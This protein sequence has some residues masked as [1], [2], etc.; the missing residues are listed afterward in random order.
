MFGG[1]AAAFAY[2]TT[3]AAASGFSQLK[4]GAGG[5][6]SGIGA[7]NDGTL[8][9][10]TDVGGA[11][12]R[13]PGGSAWQQLITKSSWPVGDFGWQNFRYP[14]ADGG[15]FAIAIAP[16]NSQVI[17]VS[18][19]QF[20]F[21]S[22]N[23][24]A[25]FTR[26]SCPQDTGSDANGGNERGNNNRLAVD[27]ANPAICF[28][29]GTLGIYFTINT[30]ST[31]TLIATTTIP[32]SSPAGVPIAFDRSSP[33][34]SG[35]TQGIFV[36]SSGHGVY[37]STNGGSGWTGP[38]GPTT[39]SCL[40]VGKDGTGYL[41]D[42]VLSVGVWVNSAGTWVLKTIAHSGGPCA[43][44]PDPNV[45]GRVACVDGDG[46][47]SVSTNSGST[48]TDVVG[49]SNHT[50][51]SPAGTVT[52][53]QNFLSGGVSLFGTCCV[54]DPSKSDT[55]YHGHGGGIGACSATAPQPTVWN[56]FSTGVE[57]LDAVRIVSP[58]GS[59]KRLVSCWDRQGF[60]NTAVGTYPSNAAPNSSAGE[61]LSAGW[62][63][64]YASG[65]SANT[66]VINASFAA[67]GTETSGYTN[68]GGG[69]WTHFASTTY[70]SGDGGCIAAADASNFLIQSGDITPRFTTNKGSTWT[71][72]TGL[73]ASGY[74]S[75]NSSFQAE[76]LAAD[77]V[78]IGTFYVFNA[79]NVNVYRSTN[80][81]S[82]FSLMGT[83]GGGVNNNTKLKA[84][85][86]NASHLFFT[87]GR[88][89][90]TTLRRSTDGGATWG[91]FGAFNEVEAFGIGKIAAGQT[92]P[93]I[94]V[95][96][97]LTSGGIYGLHRCIDGTGSTWTLLV[98]GP[99]LGIG[100]SWV[101][102]LDGDMDNYGYV[103]CSFFGNGWAYGYFP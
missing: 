37:H 1:G 8:V 95:Y 72:C 36:H 98:N 101:S 73:P 59:G 9:C 92:Y 80:Q 12:I 30:G 86:G 2:P 100:S 61:L 10:R 78:N 48:W 82:S 47:I 93:A 35:A 70:Y 81:G 57:E 40:A 31:W 66:F 55:F 44:D 63:C 88:G 33:V 58:P 20:I 16:S 15:V 17:Y 89:A 24:G 29:G 41:T 65:D 14:N 71:A 25:T 38:I 7:A 62:S 54:F 85:P 49:Q 74:A 5:L 68:D 3:A 4:I 87:A 46:Q 102:S 50:Y 39:C 22:T 23:G 51:T 27:P 42:T 79:S 11:Y 76:Y 53:L 26:T 103:Y 94:Y 75:V 32:A 90:A 6:V 69:S 97:T 84:V 18:Y 91:N 96:G 83:P 52:W 13:Q 99:P 77:R 21:V 64:D 60:V 56:D 45:S 34:T 19:Q 67:S 43:V 28:Y